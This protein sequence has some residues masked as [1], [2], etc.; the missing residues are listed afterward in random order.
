MIRR[1]VMWSSVS[2]VVLAL[3]MLTTYIALTR[4]PTPEHTI[5]G[6]S[7]MTSYA[8][9]L[10]LD[11]EDAY[12]A[13]LEELPFRHLR[14]AAHWD[15]TEVSPG[16]YQFA[17]LDRQVE[18]A[19]EY[20]ARI[21]IGVGRRLPRWPEC[22]VPQWATALSWDEQKDYLRGYIR[23][24][25]ERYR[26]EPH[27]IYWQVENE[28]YL[29]VFAHEQCGDLDEAFLE[30]EIALVRELD[31]MTPIL[32]TDS[33]NLGLWA[34]AY[35]RGDAFGTSMYVY[36]WNPEI[37]P[38]KSRLPAH[39]YRAKH[40][41]VQLLYGKKPTFL[42]ELSAEPWLTDSIIDTP[43]ATQF[44]RMNLDTFEEVLSFAKGTKFEYQ[45]LWGVE[46]WYWLKL[47]GHPEFWER[48]KTL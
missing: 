39:W 23:A 20:D 21:I 13:M 1:I 41:I 18:L 47:Q 33:G 38:F 22:H 6:M 24:V 44:E 34:P 12:V 10:G 26:D 27:V 8:R 32:L 14:L 48:A 37:G 7:F 36:L 16:E 2:V 42:I 35:K 46:W 31:P 25:V 9:E 3:V 15:I 45:Y 29:T 5:Y 19:R 28:P 11:W 40:R 17:E 43:L 30:E 4:T